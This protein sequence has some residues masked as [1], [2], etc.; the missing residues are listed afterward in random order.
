MADGTNRNITEQQRMH[1][2][3]LLEI[4]RRYIDEMVVVEKKAAD[5][6]RDGEKTLRTLIIAE[7]A[8]D[9]NFYAPMQDDGVMA[10]Q[11]ASANAGWA[12]VYLNQNGVG[13]RISHQAAADEFSRRYFERFGEERNFRPAEPFPGLVMDCIQ[14]PVEEIVKICY[15]TL[16]VNRLLFWKQ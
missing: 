9:F 7:P 12:D 14:K 13:T 3:Q 1:N 2:A 4:A 11:I 16:M 5:G 6:Q 8:I 15:D 10:M